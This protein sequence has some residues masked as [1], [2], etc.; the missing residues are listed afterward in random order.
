MKENMESGGTPE[1]KIEKFCAGFKHERKLRPDGKFAVIRFKGD[2]NDKNTEGDKYDG[3]YLFSPEG[4]LEEY[5]KDEKVKEMAD[6]YDFQE[7]ERNEKRKKY[8]LGP[9]KP[10]EN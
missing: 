1:E 4:D 9:I 6:K 7:D 8:G 10:R 3:E 5:I 2:V